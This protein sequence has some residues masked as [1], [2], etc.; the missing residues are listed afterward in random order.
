METKT[1][2]N[3]CSDSDLRQIARLASQ[4][5]G[6][7]LMGVAAT[8]EGRE[9]LTRL[10]ARWFACALRPLALIHPD[11]FD[12][13]A[14]VG[15]VEP[16]LPAADCGWASRDAVVSIGQ[17]GARSAEVTG[18]VTLPALSLLDDSP[19]FSYGPRDSMKARV[20]STAY[21]R[22]YQRVPL[23]LD[24]YRQWRSARRTSTRA[25]AG[26]CVTPDRAAEQDRATSEQRVMWV[27]M[28]WAES[29]GAESWAWEQARLAHEAGFALVM[30]FD[31]TAP[32]R[33]LERALALTNDVYLVGNALR[34]ADFASFTRALLA[35][36]AITDIHI[37]HSMLAYS[38]LPLIRQL[39]PGVRVTDST[40]I[41][42]Y[43][44][45]GFVGTSIE[46][47]SLIDEHHVISPDLVRRYRE[48]G[49]DA[50]KIAYHPLTGFTSQAIEERT[51][52]AAGEGRPLTVGYLGRLA[53]QKRP[54]LFQRVARLLAARS[55]GSFRFLM[56]G[57]GELEQEVARDAR[58]LRLDD[59]VERR[60]W[61]PAS[62][63]LRDIDVL[64]ICS[65]NEGL[66]L[67]AL[68]ADAAGVLVIST[69]VGSQYSVVA[70]GALLPLQP[71][72][73]VRG[74]YR[75]L[76]ALSDEPQLYA[77]LL[78]EQHRKVRKVTAVQSATQYFSDRYAKEMSR[79]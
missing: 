57:S 30:T 2:S 16:M 3:V 60:D 76:S 25:C 67:T 28:H 21:T 54:Y 62:E 48:A 5:L 23:V 35:R 34:G 9:V 47:S 12:A 18:H 17:T 19:T 4:D 14:H 10:G 37:H 1:V 22:L 59:V 29:G 79:D 64:L 36:H 26:W 41:A 70:D 63:L 74:A 73:F 27:A 69:D 32:Q 40:H 71:V 66:T 15:R 52:A 42:E 56:Q 7:V 8:R 75:L 49:V 77:R 20:V 51:P 43:R 55:R 61:A 78:E 46:Y 58:V 13:E 38:Q 39:S 6:G 68:E 44:D 53:V 72:P 24:S 31:R 50:S 11:G 65:E 33:Q 45:G